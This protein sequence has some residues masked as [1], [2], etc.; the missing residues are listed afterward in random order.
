[1]EAVRV[2]NAVNCGIANSVKYAKISANGWITAA[3][4]EKFKLMTSN[5]IKCVKQGYT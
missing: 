5:V 2:N 4:K 3:K 1:M